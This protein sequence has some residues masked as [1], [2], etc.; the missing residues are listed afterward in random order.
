MKAIILVGGYGTRLRPLTQRLPKPLV[1]IFDQTILSHQLSWL[2]RYGVTDVVLAAHHLHESVADAV[3]DGG[4]WGLQV[5]IVREAKPLGTAGA[6]AGLRSWLGQEP[7]FMLNGDILTGADLGAML[8]AHREMN[9]LATLG[10]VRVPD[11]SPFGMAEVDASGWIRRFVE[12]P[13]PEEATSDTINGGIYL[14]ETLALADL[15]EDHPASL[16]RDVFPRLLRG[17]AKLLGWALQGGWRDVGSPASYQALHE[18]V[19]LGRMTLT[20]NATR[21]ERGIWLAEGATLDPSAHVEGPAYLGAGAYVGPRARVG[22]LSVL[23]AG[24]R[25]EERADLE[26]AILLAGASL[27]PGARVTQAILGDGARVEADAQLHG[28][29]VLAEGSVLGQ[30]SRVGFR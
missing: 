15:I 21:D 9:A 27:G 8:L 13:S 30:G 2:A 7:F 6:L 26:R 19:L 23:S 22:P 29:A 10:L 20:L 28:P 12:K 11:P 24:A 17:G 18:D 16:E 25:L 4:A 14:M 1:P 3:G 5:R